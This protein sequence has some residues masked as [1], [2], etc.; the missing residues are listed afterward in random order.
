MKDVAFVSVAFGD[1]RYFEQIDR[2]KASILSF[3]PDANLVFFRGFFPPGSKSF[4]DS[5]YGFKP[6][7]IKVAMD[8]GFKKI[9]WLDP[10]MIMV[11][12]IED[13]LKFEMM[14]VMDDNLLYNVVS[15]K[16]YAHFGETQKDVH[17]KGWHLVG[18]SIYWFD[19]DREAT[20]KIFDAWMEAEKL[21]LFGSQYEQASEQLQGHR[22]DEAVM[23]LAM[24]QNNIIPVSAEEARYCWASN[25]MFIKKHFK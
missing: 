4:S 5:L 3:Y 17:D 11:E 13:I 10:A 9:V 6:H 15:D 18:G 24:Y 12:P 7:A 2:L 22:M 20:V 23:S 8:R 19:F 16:C 1:A 25:P 21:G 14:A